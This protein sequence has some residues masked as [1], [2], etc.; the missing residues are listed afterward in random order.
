MNKRKSLSMLGICKKAGKL[1]QGLDAVKDSIYKGK[2][3][4][5]FLTADLSERTAAQMDRIAQ[6]MRVPIC[7]SAFTMDEIGQMTGRASGVNAVADKGLAEAL[8][9]AMSLEEEMD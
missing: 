9:S 3:Q 7:R 2:A 6:E 1:E 5:V 8:V 4:I